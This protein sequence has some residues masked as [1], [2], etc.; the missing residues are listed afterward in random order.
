MDLSPLDLLA[1]NLHQFTKK[2]RDIAEFILNEPQFAFQLSADDIAVRTKTSK[3]AF[4][5]LCQKIGFN[6]YAEFRFAMSR[7][8]VG[9]APDFV[10]SDDAILRI[11][12]SYAK[13]INQIS[14]MISID[15]VEELARLFVHAKRI[16][17]IGNNRTA[18]SAKQLR[19]RMGKLGVDAEVI[20]DFITARDVIE[21]LGPEDVCII[22]SIKVMEIHY[23]DIIRELHARSCPVI[24]VT[25]TPNNKLT[26]FLHLQF[27]L[28][29]I[30]RSTTKTFLDDQAIFFVFIEIVLNVLAKQLQNE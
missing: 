3:A 23:G 14:S 26:E 15:Q 1:N 16:K 6:G 25:M 20:D 18:L 13:F 12:Y 28:P 10:S 2:E 24:L 11:T 5:R 17:I 27:A 30:S 19:M 21:Y 22:F 9:N 7:A 4:I 8:M 29:Y